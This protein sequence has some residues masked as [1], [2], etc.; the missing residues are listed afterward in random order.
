MRLV[1]SSCLAN[2]C[3]RTCLPN[4]CILMPVIWKSNEHVCL[5]L[6]VVVIEKIIWESN[7]HRIC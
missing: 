3:V 5:M 7:E 6:W 1:V 2:A 4:T